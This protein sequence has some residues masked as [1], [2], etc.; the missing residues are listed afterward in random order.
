VE[1]I[2]STEELT[3]LSLRVGSA[4]SIGDLDLG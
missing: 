4:S 3:E 1:A 2:G